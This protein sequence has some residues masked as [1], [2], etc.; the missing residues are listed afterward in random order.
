MMKAISLFARRLSATA[1]VSIAA[2]GAGAATAA[3]ADD[4]LVV[5]MPSFYENTFLP[6]NGG[7][8]RKFY[9]DAIYDYLIYLEPA[10]NRAVPGLAVDWSMSPDGKTW[11]YQLRQG[12]QFQGG[13]GELTS[14]DVKFSIERF[15]DPKSIAGP[16]SALR[17]LIA[18]V[19]APETY[20]VVVTLNN[21]DVDFT[22]GYLSNGLYTAIVSKKYFEAK[23][24]EEANAKPFG[25]GPYTLADNMRGVSVRLQAADDAARHWRVKPAFQN[26]L[27]VAVPEEATRV[28]KLRA[29]EADF[30]PI[31]YDSIK[32]VKDAG[33]Q[34]LSVRENWVP[35]VR[36][37]GLVT[38]SPKFHNPGVPWA[39]KEVRQA[40][41]H[42][43]N[44]EEIVS[45]IFHG[46]ARPTAVDTPVAEWAKVAPYSYDPA[47]AR[48]LLA[49]AGYKNGFDIT[50]KSFAT[51]PGAELPQIADAVAMYWQA[52]GI[53][54]KIQRV[55]FPSLRA[56]WTNGKAT[57]FAW[58]H[59]GLA[60]PNPLV[61]IE[62]S[63]TSKSVF[64]TYATTETEAR[65]AELAS[66]LDPG[67]RSA[68]LE[69]MGAYL[70]DEAAGIFIVI[71]NEPYGASRKVGKWET[72]NMNALSIETITRAAK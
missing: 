1:I 36:L 41:N 15:I 37:G 60:F 7:G 12:V 3:T 29:G 34:V 40:M 66:T 72:I 17:K 25:T 19:E 16:A 21:P 18:K 13:Y 35:V 22:R 30:A 71:A 59:R 68:L 32:A 31:N 8:Q 50:L 43:I 26:L 56:A 14:A 2:L 44:R 6:W 49:A 27:F 38:T 45:A 9:L 62:T 53:R 63:F 55:D 69:K 58:T 28:A 24:D 51:T 10:T 57:D 48:Q 20:K 33:L 54:T 23:G 46:E 4:T 11:T 39:K 65:Y 61:G 47:K 5:V 64:A 67:K 52:V 42:A 70:R